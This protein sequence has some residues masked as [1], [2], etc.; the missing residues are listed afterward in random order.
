MSMISKEVRVVKVNNRNF[1]GFQ[2][3]GCVIQQFSLDSE[4]CGSS[5]RFMIIGIL[6]ERKVGF[7]GLVKSE[8]EIQVVWG[9][10]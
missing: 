9:V 5:S 8:I 1:M 3:E 7:D 6:V 4:A 2:S 10:Y